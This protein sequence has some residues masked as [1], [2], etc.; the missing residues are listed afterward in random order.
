MHNT[1]ES[2]RKNRGLVVLIMALMVV[3]SIEPN[4]DAMSDMCRRWIVFF[5][6]RGSQ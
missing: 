1:K 5:F 4:I 3:Y 6:S 2:L